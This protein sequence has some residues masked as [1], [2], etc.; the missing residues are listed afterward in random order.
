MLPLK[1]KNFLKHYGYCGL[2]KDQINSQQPSTFFLKK[3]LADFL[4]IFKIINIKI[5]SV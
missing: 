2:H 5:K 1:I 4:K 3:Q